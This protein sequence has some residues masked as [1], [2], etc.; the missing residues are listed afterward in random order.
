[1][2]ETRREFIRLLNPA[3][4]KFDLSSAT[5]TDTY[6]INRVF[7]IRSFISRLYIF[8]NTRGDYFCRESPLITDVT[9]Y[10]RLGLRYSADLWRRRNYIYNLRLLIIS[11]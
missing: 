7:S 9:L 10:K 3:L 2:S 5:I 6:I 4:N 11:D 1:V 8:R